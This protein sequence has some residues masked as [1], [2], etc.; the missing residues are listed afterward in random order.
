MSDL[1]LRRSPAWYKFLSLPSLPLPWR[2]NMAHSLAK[3]TLAMQETGRNLALCTRVFLFLTGSSQCFPLFDWLL[4]L[5]TLSSLLLGWA[6]RFPTHIPAPVSTLWALIGSPQYFPCSDL[7]LWLRD[8]LL[9]PFNGVCAAF[10]SRGRLQVICT[11]NKDISLRYKLLVY[12]FSLFQGYSHCVMVS[13]L[14]DSMENLSG[15]SSSLRRVLK[16]VADLFVLWGIV[17]DS[18]SFLEVTN[19]FL[20]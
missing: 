16:C 12:F 20:D 18:G 3:I 6:L 13:Y 7:P 14:L 15:V 8:L 2:S 17:E 4:Q 5:I 11:S 19:D 1:E 9:Q 10:D